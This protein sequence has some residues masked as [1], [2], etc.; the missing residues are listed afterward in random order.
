LENSGTDRKVKYKLPNNKYEKTA[1][2]DL[3]SFNMRFIMSLCLEE[4]ANNPNSNE[5]C[6]LDKA[7]EVNL[8]PLLY[9]LGE[10]SNQEDYSIATDGFKPFKTEKFRVIKSLILEINYKIH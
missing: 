10:I 5:I 2:I 8:F 3:Y 1:D 4:G 9:L 6:H 7:N